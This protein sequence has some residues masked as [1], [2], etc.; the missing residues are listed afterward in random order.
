M[1]N[2]N[3]IK[4]IIISLVLRLLNS[5]SIQ[6]FFQPDEYWQS[7]EISHNLI[8]DYGYKTWEWRALGLEGGIRSPLYPYL[9]VPI[10]SLLKRFQLDD[11]I[12]L[13][14]TFLTCRNRHRFN[15]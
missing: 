15:F 1:I 4:V 7:L 3:L 11:T 9:F 5:I 14:S 10:Y 8:F 6:T 2:N 13:V 12:L